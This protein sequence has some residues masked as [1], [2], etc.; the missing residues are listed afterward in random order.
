MLASSP[1]PRRL[2]AVLL[3]VLGLVLSWQVITR[4][5]AAY[6]ADV[7]PEAALRLRATEP[8]ALLNLAVKAR[9]IDR[10]NPPDD[11][12][13]AFADTARG[14]A[15][16][17][18]RQGERGAQ[19]PPEENLPQG[20]GPVE[21]RHEGERSV[22]EREDQ[23]AGGANADQV[24]AWA[25][26][27]LGADPLNA[28]ALRILGQLA[29]EARD[30]ERAGKLMQAAFA[31]S[32]REVFAIA[33]L[34]Q[35]RFDEEDYT[36]TLD[37]ADALLRTRPQLVKDATR[38]LAR[39]AESKSE[40]AAI[41]QALARNP[42]WRAAFFAALPGTIS[43]ARTPLDL[44]LSI[45]DT[46]TPPTN[47][48]LKGYMNFLIQNKFH[49]LAY[50]TWLQFLP[51]EQ[52][53]KTG[54]LFNGSF[55]ITPSGLP[56][57]WSLVPGSGVTIE[58]A[59]RTDASGQHAL[60]IAFG[61]GR[62]EFRPVGQ[63]TMLGPGDYRLEGKYRGEIIG[64]RGLKW[65]ISCAGG[66]QIGE[67]EMTGGIVSAWRDFEFRFTVPETNCRAQHLRLELDARMASERLVS[68]S[69]WYDELSIARLARTEDVS[70]EDG[71]RP[72]AGSEAPPQADRGN[73]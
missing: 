58:I 32:R 28:R 41:K 7:A 62:V 4:G 39:I 12:T 43:D 14:A 65:R 40:V 10:T 47:A 73:P 21:A 49:E 35:K 24:R 57:D 70:T 64:P 33:W 23:R 1:P 8:T 61:H 25:E 29:D 2:R 67:S 42:P 31:R 66:P 53:T 50:Y 51:P 68:G 11:R 36:A 45:R 19:D 44:L 71:E 5:F 63:L 9:A 55:E 6:L 3:I 59:P 72:A 13:A 48:D 38:V 16:E 56:F 17:T 20:R 34:M 60:Y 15:D 30:E 18:A 52:L 27:A 37:Y 69:I 22:D 46:P 54:L 26:A